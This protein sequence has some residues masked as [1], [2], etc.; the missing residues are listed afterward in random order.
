MNANITENLFAALNIV[1]LERINA[2][3]FKIISNLPSWFR[4]F[5]QHKYSLG[6]EISIL[7]EEF[8]FLQ[9]FLFDAEEF[10]S[11]SNCKNLTSG[12]WIQIDPQGKEYQ[13]EARATFVEDKKILL[14]EVLEESYRHRQNIIQEARQR[15]LNYQKLIKNNQKQEILIHCLIHDIAGQ[16][17]AMNG[18]LSL[19]EFENLTPQGRNYLE[20]CQQ[21]SFNQENLMRK[22]LDTFSAE[23]MALEKFVVDSE[24]APNIL[25]CVNDVVETLKPS[26]TLNNINLILADAI[27]PLADWKVQGDKSRLDRV[28]F[29]ILENAVRYSPPESTVIIRLQSKENYIYVSV[30]DEGSGVPLE[31][32]NTLF[33]KFSQGKDKSSGKSGLGLY[34]C[35]ITVERWGGSIG[36]VPRSEGGS[37]FWFCL[38]RF[39]S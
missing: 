30:D 2:G 11:N 24:E 12:I 6:M 13:F 22:V 38:P 25:S 35:R 28:I 4:E 33:Q 10:W 20:V 39:L 5:C 3:L 15:Q 36:Y 31:T 27:D 26:F 34:F 37:C 16:L 19:L 21:Q 23:M 7:Q 8:Y 9:N 18:C 17:N 32:V 14:I 1:V 29:N